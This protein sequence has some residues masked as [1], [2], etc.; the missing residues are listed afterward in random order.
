MSFRNFTAHPVR[1]FIFRLNLTSIARV[2]IS[3]AAVIPLRF[4][5]IVPLL[6]RFVFVQTQLLTLSTVAADSHPLPYFVKYELPLTATIAIFRTFFS[7]FGKT[8]TDCSYFRNFPTYSYFSLVDST[9]FKSVS[10]AHSISWNLANSTSR[11]TLETNLISKLMLIEC[12]A[13]VF[14]AAFVFTLHP[15]P[16]NQPRNVS[17]KDAFR[18]SFSRRFNLFLG[19]FRYNSSEISHGY[20]MLNILPNVRS[21]QTRCR[22][23]FRTENNLAA[24][25]KS[26]I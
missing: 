22:V 25:S 24:A 2:P 21:K 18:I 11:I 8:I 7:S 5:S 9:Y 23:S 15:L 1:I 20:R 17:S 12:R 6:R 26:I 4:F 13:I 10:R 14:H 19:I 3:S 16:F